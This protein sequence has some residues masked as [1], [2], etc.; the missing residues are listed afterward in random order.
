MKITENVH[1]D[2]VTVLNEKEISEA[3]KED[4]KKNFTADSKNATIT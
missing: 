2:M 1:F 4:I 3:E